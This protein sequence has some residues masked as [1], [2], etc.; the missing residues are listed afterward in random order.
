M[1][2]FLL[3]LRAILVFCILTGCSKVFDG[4]VIPYYKKLYLYGNYSN[5]TVN[6]NR[7]PIGPALALDLSKTSRAVQISTGQAPTVTNAANNRVLLS[8][9][10]VRFRDELGIYEKLS[11]VTE[12]FRNGKW[13]S[14]VE[15][16]LDVRPTQSLDY[17]LVLDQSSSLGT[18][19]AA[20]VK[21]Y[22][23]Q[24][25]DN[26]AAKGIAAR[27]GVVAFSDRIES[28]PLTQPAS[29]ATVKAFINQRQGT[30]ATKLYEAIDTGI[31]LLSASNA[32]GRALVVFTDGRNNAWSDTKY[33]T[34][35]YISGRLAQS[36]VNRVSKISSYTIGLEGKGGVDRDALA[37]LA[38]NGGISEIASDGGAL[39]KVFQ[40]FAAS[41]TT[42]YSLV[43]NRNNSPLS[44][45]LPLRFSIT[46]KLQ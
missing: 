40:K 42:V 33:Q 15:N 18:G 19:D 36:G 6:S 45:L 43:Y 34:V 38:Q 30:D 23:N 26:V 35:Q 39:D 1:N 37:S 7:T 44:E 46:T 29:Y 17:I 5:F 2:N 25:I 13:E 41:V 11:V 16:T 9:N 14:D 24:F 12:E 10:N 20:L 28:M 4:E 32:E 3:A 27:V 8:F 21:Q 22:A 31:N